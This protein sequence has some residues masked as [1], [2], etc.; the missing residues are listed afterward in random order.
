[1]EVTLHPDHPAE[2]LSVGDSLASGKSWQL[3]TPRIAVG[4]SCA[5]AV[6]GSGWIFVD[7]GLYRVEPRKDSAVQF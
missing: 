7:H 6:S 2:L 4:Y 5:V 3:F 1:F